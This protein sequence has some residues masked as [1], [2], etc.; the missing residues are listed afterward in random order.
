MR[1]AEQ[2]RY[3]ILAA[4]REGNRLLAHHL[5]PIGLTPSQAE[6]IRVL[7]DNEPLTL[8]GL[9]ELLV[10]EAGTNP[11]RLVDRLVIATHVE[12]VEAKDDRRQVML[13]LTPEGRELDFAVRAIEQAMYEQIDQ[14]A[15]PD[16]A[17]LDYLKRLSLG[18]DA[19]TAVA[20]R[21]AL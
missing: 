19:G 10:C 7:A 11:S 17:I 13:T 4:Q 1:A 8:S 16:R 20:R 2:V 14:I 3:L 18:T 5:R 6:V 15:L 21:L 9:G 12:R